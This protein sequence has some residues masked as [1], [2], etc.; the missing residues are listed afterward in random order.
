MNH[1]LENSIAYEDYVRMKAQTIPQHRMKEFLDSLNGKGT[2]EVQQYVH[3]PITMYQQ[4][5]HYIYMDSADV[6]GSLL[7]LARPI[8]SVQQQTAAQGSPIEQQHIQVHH[9]QAPQG[10]QLE[11]QRGHQAK[12][13]QAQ[14]EAHSSPEGH[15]TNQP[16]TSVS[17]QERRPSSSGVPQ[18]VKKRK[19]DLPLE[20]NYAISQ[21][22]VQNSASTVLTLSAQ[23]QQQAYIPIRQELLT[24][25]SSQLYG[26]VPATTSAAGQLPNVESWAVYSAHATCPDAQN[27]VHTAVPQDGCSIIQMGDIPVMTSI[28]LEENKEKLQASGEAKKN[29]QEKVAHTSGA[30]SFPM[31]FVNVNG[32]LHIPVTVQAGGRVYQPVKYWDQQQ[33]PASSY[34]KKQ[35]PPPPKLLVTTPK[36]RMILLG[37]KPQIIQAL[38][39]EQHTP[40]QTDPELPNTLKPE[41]GA[42]FWKTWAQI[43]NEEILKEAEN[44]PPGLG[45]RK[46]MQFREDVLSV[47]IAE[48][49]YGLCLMTKEARKPDGSSYEADSLYYLFLCIQK[50]MFDNDRIDNI[51]SDLYYTKFLERLHEA[52]KDW[53][54]GVSPLGYMIPSCISEEMLWDCKQLGAHS[55]TT[56]LFTLMYFNTKYFML[57]TVEQHSKLAF[58]KIL[59]QTRKNPSNG[60]DKSSTIRFLRLYGQIQVG[61]KALEE[62]CVE[63]LEN[64][65]NPLRCPIKLYDFYRFKCPQGA[66]GPSD[67]FYLIPE[68]V[69]APNSPIW[70]SAQSVGE[71]VMEQMLTRILMV[72]EVQEAHT[73]PHV[74]AYQ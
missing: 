42:Y 27:V 52:L 51:F 70:Y 26:L 31:Q 5:G 17:H 74:S 67:T 2:E 61:Q 9:V 7:E 73:T 32:N 39:A 10:H 38:T 34:L 53:H 60:K 72:R 18:P 24:V 22:S 13:V 71:E 28:K 56:L 20:G 25:D 35:Q 65:D 64:P 46:L 44:K 50:H 68:P 48:L 21:A 43:K 29:F 8:T 54:P 1:S 69:V 47:S 33:G 3:S 19:I 30:S 58:S 15:S 62:T 11:V 6:A 23:T 55:P 57:K 45:R 14:L 49:N 41:E 36:W 63:Q 4:R 59:K 16:G 66:K 40:S 37:C 12:Q